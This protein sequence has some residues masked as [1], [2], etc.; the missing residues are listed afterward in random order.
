MGIR[1]RKLMRVV[2]AA[3]PFLDR[4]LSAGSAAR[5]IWETLRPMRRLVLLFS[6]VPLAVI[7]VFGSLASAR[8][9]VANTWA[10]FY[11]PG[12]DTTVTSVQRGVVTVDP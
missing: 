10:G 12:S 1:C 7:V 4:G 2:D 11:D 9:T 3:A 5:R 8:P 6:F